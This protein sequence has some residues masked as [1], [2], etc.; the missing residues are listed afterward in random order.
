MGAIYPSTFFGCELQSFEGISHSD[1]CLISLIMELGGTQLVVLIVPQN[2]S[3]ELN[4]SV[5]VH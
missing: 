4:S 5:S 3:E 1:V 2:T